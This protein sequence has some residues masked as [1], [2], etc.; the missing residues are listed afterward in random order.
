MYVEDFVVL[1]HQASQVLEQRRFQPVIAAVGEKL[2]EGFTDNF[3]KSRAPDGTP[4]APRK[5]KK[6]KNPLL[7]LTA[8]MIRSVGT[9][10]PGH[11]ESYGDDAGI[12][13]T[14]DFKAG[15]HQFGT[16]YMSK[17]PFLDVTE[18]VLDQCTEIVANGITIV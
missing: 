6:A 1:C 15:F 12:L 18:Q 16:R 17:R 10:A 8:A 9:T 13:G 11:I 4:W 14:S 7:I 2:K 5:S 3:A